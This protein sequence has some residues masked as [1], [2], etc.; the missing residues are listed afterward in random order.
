MQTRL[1]RLQYDCFETINHENIECPI[2]IE[3]SLPDYCPDIQKVLKC[4]PYANICSY[5]FTQDRFMCEGKLVLHVQYVDEKSST[6]RVCDIRQDFSHSREISRQES[7]CFGNVTASIG[8]LVCRA[9]SA[10]KLDIHVPVLL[11][12]TVYSQKK[13][14]IDCNCD[15]LEEMTEKVLV[16][17]AVFGANHNFTIEEELE[18]SERMPPIDCILRNEIQ[19]SSL[20]TNVVNNKVELT[21]VADICMV[22]RS[23]SESF[24]VQKMQYSLPFEEIIT[25][26]GIDSDCMVNP[27]INICEFNLQ[28]KEDQMGEYTI[29]DMYLKMSACLFVYKEKEVDIIVDAYST[30]Q[31]CKMKYEDL[32]FNHN[33]VPYSEKIPMTKS[34]FLAD[35]ELEKVLDYWC[36]EVSVASYC[37]KNK[38]SYRAKFNICLSYKG[39]TGEIFTITKNFDFT[40]SRDFN[41]YCQR[42]CEA[43]ISVKIKDYRIVDGNNIE[44]SLECMLVSNDYECTTKKMLTSVEKELSEELSDN[45]SIRIYYSQKSEKLWDIGKKYSIAVSSIVDNNKLS[46]AELANGEPLLIF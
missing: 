13:T 26:N 6:I 46:D 19:L 1:S 4:I 11:G 3:Y 41:E 37:E 7:K 39:K 42:K 32:S 18:L 16:S 2:D 9:I 23:C 27:E 12:M 25:I 15:E 8:H 22:Y 40:T 38:L 17:D 45:G 34:V 31:K 29:C 14:E 21:G 30:K 5:S 10:R 44:F 36:E 33:L 35:D 43:K 24:S 28:P 20:K